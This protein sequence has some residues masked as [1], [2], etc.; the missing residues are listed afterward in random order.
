MVAV[1]NNPAS[2][3]HGPSET[4]RVDRSPYAVRM[5][6]EAASGLIS[7]LTVAPAVSI[8]DRAIVSNA[9][10]LQ[11]L[12]P[13]LFD[14]VKTLVTRPLFFLRQP[15]FLLIW[16]VYSGTYAAANTIDA[17]CER[18]KQS[19]TVPKFVGSSATNVTLSVLKDMSFA[20][21]FGTGA[22]KVMPPVSYALFGTR[23]SM[24]VLASF[25][26]PDYVSKSMQ[27]TVGTSKAFSDTAAQ[28]I[29]PCSMQFL[30]SPLHLYGLDRYNR[31]T[32]VSAADRWGFIKREYLK[33][34]LAR[35]A[36]IFPAF[37]VGGVVNKRVRAEGKS[38]F[39]K[40][41]EQQLVAAA[42]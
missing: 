32:G 28:L 24:T 42:Y 6:V 8:V 2:T 21:M 38:R 12:V 30:S 23:D 17:T 39:C 4:E 1:N 34:S 11:P 33:T 9:S 40:Q 16:G 13:C 37:G 27:G 20:R 31:P 7:A 35:I 25:T 29:T 18:S 15:S 3:P 14:G 36:R 10:G 41:P 26:L 5:C 22:P 19:P